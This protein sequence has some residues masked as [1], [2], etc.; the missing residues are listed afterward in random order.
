MIGNLMIHS[1][2]FAIYFNCIPFNSAVI[3]MLA[4]L[5]TIG[6][7]EFVAKLL[8]MESFWNFIIVVLQKHPFINDRVIRFYIKDIRNIQ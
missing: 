6:R 2:R 1:F 8:K 5:I 4:P 3:E 7:S